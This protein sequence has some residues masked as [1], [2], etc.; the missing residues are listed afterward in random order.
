MTE[1]IGP[2]RACPACGGGE[3]TFRGRKQIEAT[4]DQGPM[5]ETK[6]L[7]RVCGKTWKELEPGTLRKA[8]P[9][10]K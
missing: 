2:G 1:P 8:P 6:Y 5:L 3:Y 10:P 7:C 9:K 4:A